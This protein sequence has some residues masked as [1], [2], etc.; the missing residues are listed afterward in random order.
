MPLLM[1][2]FTRVSYVKMLK[3]NERFQIFLIKFSLKKPR[4]STDDIIIFEL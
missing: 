1:V 2:T 3:M 4:V